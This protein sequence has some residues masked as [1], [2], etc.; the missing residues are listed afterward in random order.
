MG[1]NKSYDWQRFWIHFVCGALFGAGIGFC[2]W[3]QNWPSGLPAWVYITFLS[4][5][6]ALLG[7]IYGDSFWERLL[8]F[9]GRWGW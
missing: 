9:I 7:G 4:L 8:R 5:A 1:E 3:L 6:I 2:F